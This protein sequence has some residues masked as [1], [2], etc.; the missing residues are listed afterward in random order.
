MAL[1]YRVY[2]FAVDSVNDLTI[3]KTIYTT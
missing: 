3:P 2:L 1:I